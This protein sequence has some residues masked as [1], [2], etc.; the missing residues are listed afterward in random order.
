MILIM[1]FNQIK[2]KM[3]YNLEYQEEVSFIASNIEEIYEKHQKEFKE[4]DP[5]IQ[6]SGS[7]PNNSHIKSWVLER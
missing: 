6:T 2:H 4:N 1:F 7:G 3:K 5:E